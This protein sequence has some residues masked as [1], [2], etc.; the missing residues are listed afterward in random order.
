MGEFE[1]FGLVHMRLPMSA[2]II[3]PSSD[4]NG[5]DG[6]MS[7]AFSLRLLRGGRSRGLHRGLHA[8]GFGF[9][10]EPTGGP[11]PMRPSAH[12]VESAAWKTRL[13]PGPTST[14]RRHAGCR[15]RGCRGRRSP[16]ESAATRGT[17]RRCRGDFGDRQLVA[18]CPARRDLDVA[19]VQHGASIP[20]TSGTPD[21]HG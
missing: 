21:S 13:A 8:P 6:A 5:G 14:G 12:A 11:Y 1:A 9:T 20:R 7:R 16:S 19:P 4:V 2:R 3:T 10:G 15:P 17:S 18:R